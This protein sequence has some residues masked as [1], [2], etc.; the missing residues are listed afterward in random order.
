MSYHLHEHTDETPVFFSFKTS[1]S[2]LISP[3]TPS[4]I[5]YSDYNPSTNTPIICPLSISICKNIHQAKSAI[6]ATML[7]LGCTDL[8]L[9]AIN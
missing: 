9:C 4:H 6:C 8:P 5:F 1:T 3:C 7:S 2:S